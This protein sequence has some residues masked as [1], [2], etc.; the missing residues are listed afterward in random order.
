[1]ADLPKR[2]RFF[3]ASRWRSWLPPII[4]V[5]VVIGALML[6]GPHGVSKTF[7]YRLF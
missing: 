1:M 6:F 4:V 3:V 2:H 7:Q 5:L